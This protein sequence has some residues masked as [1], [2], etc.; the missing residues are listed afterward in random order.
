MMINNATIPDAVS[1][2][3]SITPSLSLEEVPLEDALGRVLAYD[4]KARL[5]LPPFHRSVYDGYAFRSAET[6][7]ASDRSPAMFR[8]TGNI[9]AGDFSPDE[10]GEGCCVRIMTGAPLPEGTDC[11]INYE[12]VTVKENML[13]LTE[14]LFPGQNVDHRGDEMSSGSP[15]LKK[16]DLLTPSHLGILASQGFDRIPVYR[17]PRAS[18]LST[19]SELLRPGQP[20]SPGKIYDSNLTVFRA[21]L[22]QEG[23]C[24]TQCR[25]VSDDEAT[26]RSALLDLSCDHDLIITTGGASVGDKDYICRALEQAGAR[27]LFSHVRMK[28][29]S[30]CYGAKLRDSIVISLSGNPGAAL[31]AWYIIAL[32]AIRK[33]AGKSDYEL[34]EMM[35]PLSEDCRKTCP[36]PRILKGHIETAGSETYFTA[37]EGQ[38]NGMQTSFLHMDALAELPPTDTPLPAGTM[39]R[40]FLPGFSPCRRDTELS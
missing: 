21:L 6:V 30:C 10:P 18:V 8:I 4:L 19:G 9:A 2:L 26:I 3:L 32:P 7:N 37:H 16:G 23:C 20:L 31:T 5:D 40:V 33:L 28:P 22:Q 36:H 27:I 25:H 14:P 1:A 39:A 15:L 24:T 34:R 13:L 11:V 12:R 38:K 35:L 29:G 17:K